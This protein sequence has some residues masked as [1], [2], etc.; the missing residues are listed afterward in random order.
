MTRR[1][2]ARKVMSRH[3]RR[4]QGADSGA[5]GTDPQSLH[6]HG[7]RLLPDTLEVFPQ[8]IRRLLDPLRRP[9]KQLAE[10]ILKVTLPIRE[11]I[12]DIRGDD[13]YLSRV[14]QR[15]PSE[16]ARPRPVPSARCG[17]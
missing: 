5:Y 14:V 4:S 3:R 15:G 16:H 6:T 2:C 11:R 10:D 9:Q 1:L 17:R 7:A 12:L 8:R 13:E